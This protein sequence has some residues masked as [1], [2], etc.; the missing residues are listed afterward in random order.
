[1]YCDTHN[2]VI[3]GLDDGPQTLGESIELIQQAQSQNISHVIATPHVN[4]RQFG[5]TQEAIKQNF[6]IVQNELQKRKID[7]SLSLSQELT[8]SVNLFEKYPFPSL[9]PI[10]NN[11]EN[12]YFLIEITTLA[13]PYY[14]EDTLNYLQH[15]E[16]NC[17]WAHPER[18]IAVQS[19]WKIVRRMKEHSNLIIQVTAGSLLGNFGKK[20]EKVSW[21]LLKKGLVD[22]VASDA[23]HISSRPFQLD[24]AMTLIN[25]RLKKE[26][27]QR[28]VNNM[29]VLKGADY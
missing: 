21:K 22:L 26:A 20:I 19:D 8:L 25:S 15:H 2:H 4:H 29:N 12:R 17:I 10:K 6:F 28:I 16:L 3:F 14:F 18:N 1:M 9:F 7:V 24:E 11:E 13:I 5:T 23:H 27:Y